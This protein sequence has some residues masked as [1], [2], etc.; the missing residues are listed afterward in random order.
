[1]P[2]PVSFGIIIQCKQGGDT[3]T[4]KQ[5]ISCLGAI[6]LLIPG[7]G[8]VPISKQFVGNTV[9]PKQQVIKLQ[10]GGSH[11]DSWQ[12]FDIKIDYE[13]KQDDDKFNISGRAVLSQHYVMTYDI[14]NDLDLYLFFID[15]NSR[16]LETNILARS[17][18]QNTD[19]TL[20]F[21]KLYKA[22]PG[23]TGISFGYNGHVSADKGN[24]TFYLLPLDH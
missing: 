24:G 14:L 20:Q 3:M 4:I 15:G 13:Y 2:T 16:V 8:C 12:N 11:M 17:V 19:E 18:A 7:S 1:M 23:T 21:T 9:S 5:I 22:P 6:F 10:S